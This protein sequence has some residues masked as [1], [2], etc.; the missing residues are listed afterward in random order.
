MGRDAW[1]VRFF[2]SL[3]FVQ[4]DIAARRVQ[5]DIVARIVQNYLTV[6]R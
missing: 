3:R 5:N 2:T 1:L 6:G 4:N